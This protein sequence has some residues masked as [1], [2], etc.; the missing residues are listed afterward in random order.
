LIKKEETVAEFV[1]SNRMIAKTNISV[2]YNYIIGFPEET[3]EDV[4]LTVK[5]AM[6]MLDENPNAVNSTFYLLT[7]YPGTEIGE[8]YLKD[9]MPTT[10]EGWATFGRHNFTANWHSPETLKLYERIYFSSK[11]VGRRLMGVFPKDTELRDLAA[12]MVSKWREFDFADDAEW[13]DLT[14][15]GWKVLK[16]LFGANAY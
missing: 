6:Q 14:K 16:R 5:L 8:K 12:E 10:L 15:R 1:E 4:K 13:N 9:Q 2:W 3:I 11:F 7:P